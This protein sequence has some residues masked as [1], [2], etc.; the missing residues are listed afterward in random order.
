MH[1]SAEPGALELADWASL[2]EIL[3]GS[4]TDKEEVW[5]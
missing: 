3:L 2:P 1:L 4:H 5:N